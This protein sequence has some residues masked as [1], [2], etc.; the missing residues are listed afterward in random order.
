MNH[1]VFSQVVLFVG[2]FAACSVVADDIQEQQMTRKP[3][4]VVVDNDQRVALVANKTSGSISVVGLV[5]RTVISESKIGT[6]LSCI[7]KGIEQETYL[8]TDLDKHEL[9]C[10]RLTDN[11]AQV[12]SRTPVAKYPV[13]IAVDRE[14]KRCSVTSLWSRRVTLINMANEPETI[15]MIDLAFAPKAQCYF[16]N[17][18][19]VADA[20]GDNMAVIDLLTNQIEFT[21]T[22]PGHAP[23][24]L[25][26]SN[27]NRLIMAQSMLNGLAHSVRNDVHWGLMVSNDVRWIRL[28]RLLKRDAD[29]YNG[30]TTRP[31]GGAGEAK[32]DPGELAV[33]KDD[34]V[35]VTLGGVDEIAFGK[36]SDIGFSYVRV[37]RRPIAVALYDND[38]KAVVANHLD[39]SISVVDLKNSKRLATIALGPG[40]KLTEIARGESLFFDARLSHDRWMSC[41]SCHTEGHTNSLLNDNF[42]DQSFGAPKRVLSLLGRHGTAP[43][44]WNGSSESLSVQ[45]KNSIE[46]TMQGDRKPREDEIAA[47][48]AYLKTLDAPPSIDVARDTVNLDA[49]ARGRTVFLSNN[50]N[51][52][53]QEL[54]YTSPNTYQVGLE[55]QLG[56][57]EFNPPTLIG[58]GQRYKLFHD[59]RASGLEEVFRK[60]KHQIK[61]DLSDEQLDDLILF[62]RS[63]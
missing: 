35:V 48:A 30:A 4:G 38:T 13:N 17:K 14:N 8:C 18:L 10:F 37:G 28:D 32:G 34:T 36:V 21:R 26:L 19:M 44:A 5:G 43:F 63:L 27:D 50:C 39:D 56:N 59:N 11:K 31:L 2:L 20:F 54:N 15:A 42:S 55:D 3:L 45:V 29:I 9:V 52:C 40:R 57:K 12:I 7:S 24:T 23:S 16:E 58:V 51:S 33:A 1:F 25:A 41:H 6:Q 60:Y 46:Q 61:G 22:L 62:L 53:H 49:I 47:I